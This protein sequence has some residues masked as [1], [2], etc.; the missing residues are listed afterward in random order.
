[1]I[2]G[3][4][5]G[6]ASGK[7]AVS[8]YLAELGIPVV[9]ADVV[10]RQVVEPGQPALVS[11]AQHFGHELIQA[12]GSLDRAALRQRIFNN[13]QEKQ[14]LEALLHPLIRTTIRKQLDDAQGPYKLLV[15]PLLLENGLES[16]V[17]RVLVID[18]PVDAQLNR[19]AARDNNSR[20]QIEQIVA[21]QL[22]REQRVA[23]ADDVICNDRDLEHLQKQTLALHQ[24]YLEL[25]KA[26]DRI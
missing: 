11:I 13:H 20:E 1:M 12:D 16:M 23:K 8:D 21:A 14:W 25:A 3:L 26:H 4:T 9:D 24:R 7:T 15:A 5:G 17:D 22:P 19:G 18:A 6:I 10:A 2:V